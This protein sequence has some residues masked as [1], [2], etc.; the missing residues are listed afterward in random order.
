MHFVMFLSVHYEERLSTYFSCVAELG[1]NLPITGEQIFL[2]LQWPTLIIIK[3]N[4]VN[5]HTHFF[6]AVGNSSCIRV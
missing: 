4:L 3:I 5:Y 1:N 2:K 6:L